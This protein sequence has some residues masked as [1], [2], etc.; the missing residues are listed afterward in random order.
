M[1]LGILAQRDG[2]VPE[3]RDSDESS[4]AKSLTVLCPVCIVTEELG[5]G[6]RKEGSAPRSY[7]PEWQAHIISDDQGGG[8]VFP[9]PSL[10]QAVASL[11]P[12]SK[13]GSLTLLQGTRG[14]GKQDREVSSIIFT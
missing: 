13:C 4:V 1:L 14:P 11:A 10:H 7:V 3:S 9:R 6:P 8:G 5:K 2:L 12:S